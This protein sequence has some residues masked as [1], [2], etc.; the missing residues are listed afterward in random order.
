MVSAENVDTT[1]VN[2]NLFML[3]RIVSAPRIE[4]ILGSEWA[5]AGELARVATVAFEEE[6]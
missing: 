1:Q 2:R 5:T 4:T 3:G 6:V